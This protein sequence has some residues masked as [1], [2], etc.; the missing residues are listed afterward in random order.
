[1]RSRSGT[2]TRR[3]G[4]KPEGARAWHETGQGWERGETYDELGERILAVLRRIVAE[5]ADERVLV[6][7]HGGAVRA[8]RAHL[9]GRSVVESRR[10]SPAIANCEVF[11]VG[12]EGGEFRRLD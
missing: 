8:I 3:V 7:G 10:G 11:R 1:M 6:V 2:Y 12:S 5:H 9:E 4:P